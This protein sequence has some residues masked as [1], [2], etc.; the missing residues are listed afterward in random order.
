MVALS[1]ASEA[2]ENGK[3]GTVRPLPAM[4]YSAIHNSW[5]PA[6]KRTIDS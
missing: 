2:A 1:A 4:S 6:V 3:A 5:V